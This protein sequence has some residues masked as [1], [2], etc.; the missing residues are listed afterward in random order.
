MIYEQVEDDGSHVGIHVV[1]GQNNVG[2]SWGVTEDKL[3]GSIKF[4]QLDD[5]SIPEEDKGVICIDFINKQALE[6]LIRNLN[7]LLSEML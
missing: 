5:S 2:K 3:Q 7:S 4:Q 1:L 6:A